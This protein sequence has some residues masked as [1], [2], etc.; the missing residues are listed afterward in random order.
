M[1]LNKIFNKADDYSAHVS[2]Q[3]ITFGDQGQ[4]NFTSKSYY[5]NKKENKSCLYMYHYTEV[6]QIVQNH[7][8]PFDQQIKLVYS[9]V[10]KISNIG[11][12]C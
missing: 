10:C 4:N 2:K 9:V 1:N 8:I 6:H 5:E 11:K 12:L 3:I 7:Q